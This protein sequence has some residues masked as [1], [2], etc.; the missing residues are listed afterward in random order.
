MFLNCES[1]AKMLRTNEATL[2]RWVKQGSIISYRIGN[3]VKFD[4]KELERW[5]SK[6]KIRI[7]NLED[8]CEDTNFSSPLVKALNNGTVLFLKKDSMEEVFKEVVS[9]IKDDIC[10]KIDREKLYQS[11][12]DR[13]NIIPTIIKDGVSIPHPKVVGEFKF[14]RSFVIVTVNENFIS[15]PKNIDEKERKVKI[16]F[17]IFSKT[18]SEHLKTLA[19]ISKL[20]LKYDVVKE[21]DHTTTTQSILSKLIDIDKDLLEG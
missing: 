12:I 11:L 4:L 10:D 17:F 20:C 6:S 2:K 19:E 7:R 18:S 8:I 9:T 21:C 15:L 1:A 16:S 5:A 3:E 13:E 14:K